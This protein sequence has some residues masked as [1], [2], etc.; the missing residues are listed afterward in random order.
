MELE[1]ILMEL[2]ILTTRYTKDLKNKCDKKL[3]TENFNLNKANNEDR[4]DDI[5]IIQ[6]KMKTLEEDILI[7]E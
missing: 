5:V 3:S 4:H 6:E 7:E 2:K 1:M